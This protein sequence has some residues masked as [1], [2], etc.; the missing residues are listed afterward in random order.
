MARVLLTY[1]KTAPT[2][3][4]FIFPFG[5]QANRQ[6]AK[7]NA[8]RGTETW[9]DKL[10]PLDRKPV[11]QELQLCYSLRGPEPTA[12]PPEWPWSVRQTAVYH[13][14]DLNNGD[15]V[16]INLKSNTDMAPRIANVLRTPVRSGTQT[17]SDLSTAFRAALAT[18]FTFC[19][20]GAENW[21]VYIGFLE[22]Q[23]HEKTRYALLVAVPKLA[24]RSEASSAQTFRANTAPDL[25]RR[26]PALQTITRAVT[27]SPFK[28]WRSMTISRPTTSSITEEIEMRVPDAPSGHDMVDPV[29]FSYDDLRTIQYIE[30]QV[31]MAV[32]A[33]RSNLSIVSELSGYYRNL[34]ESQAFRDAL[35]E[36]GES[37]LR[38][39]LVRITS[40]SNNLRLHQS[41]GETLLRLIADRKS[42]VGT[43]HVTP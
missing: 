9:V 13:A 17:I 10:S 32:L 29:E 21:S 19:E 42:L 34:G 36:L 1:L 28:T 3:L 26:A 24:G 12:R 6:S 2:F 16:W 22:D 27:N 11:Y 14:F 35:G 33:I 40:I 38:L 30:D 4:D 18:H 8:F 41:R 25:P 43:W 23:L 5:K 31:N 39:F 7:F 15:A 20:W 37:A